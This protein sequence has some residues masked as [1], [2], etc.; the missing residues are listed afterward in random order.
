VLRHFDY[1]GTSFEAKARKP[2][3][4]YF[5]HVQQHTNAERGECLFI[6]DLPTNIEAAERFGWNGIVDPPNSRSARWQY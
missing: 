1:L 4:E 6:D 2:E 5:A 3:P